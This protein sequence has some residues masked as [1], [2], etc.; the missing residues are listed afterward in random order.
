M[1]EPEMHSTALDR[2]RLEADLRR[3]IERNEFELRYQ[4]ILDLHT[5]TVTALEALVRWRHPERGEIQPAAFIPAAEKSGLIVPLG[6][7]VL[8]E[9][10]RAAVRFQSYANGSGPVGICVNLSPRQFT[11]PS[12]TADVRRALRSSG[13]HPAALTLEITEGVLVED[14]DEAIRTLGTLKQV[15]VR[16]ALDD[17][18]TGYASLSYL[19]R[20]PIDILKVDR[21]FV[22][23]GRWSDHAWIFTDEIVRF[24]QRLG[25]QT[26]AEGI[27]EHQQLSALRKS[28]CELGQGFLFARPLGEA[29]VGEYLRRNRLPSEILD[30]ASAS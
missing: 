20:L 9:A 2:L 5:G 11:S 16:V 1:F 25:L 27:E 18:G 12:L 24:G 15:G 7:W 29:D 13:L 28:G 30:A 26:L 10:C 14:V 4:P 19:R 23:D 6:R 21:S 22:E 8:D 3:A 17:F